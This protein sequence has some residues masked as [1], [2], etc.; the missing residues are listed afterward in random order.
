MTDFVQRYL[1]AIIG[2]GTGVEGSVQGGIYT[3]SNHRIS[4][5][6]IAWGGETQGQATLRIYGLS[7]SLMNTLTT[8]GPIM[9]EILY[10]NS[11]QILAGTDPNNLTTVFNGSIQTA[12]AD[13]NAAPDVV[14]EI[15]AIS[16][17]VAAMAPA[18]ST[19]PPANTVVS[20]DSL[21][22]NWANLLK[23]GYLNVDVSTVVQNVTYN[24]SILDQIKACAYANDIDYSTDNLTLKIK[25]RFSSYPSDVPIISPTT[26][27]VGYPRFSSN[28]LSVKS[29]FLPSALLGGQIQIKNSSVSAANGFWTTF[30]IQHELESLMPNGKWFTT[31]EAFP[32]GL[33]T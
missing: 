8:I 27:M 24:G 26:G 29:L 6:I 31:L 25:N 16:A 23:W 10:K 30:A 19:S 5:D 28:G 32:S 21:M 12:N 7:K 1:T 18:V 2:I 20:I 14:F 17:A 11:V 15:T 9:T 13:Y 3:F 4:V 33:T 22:H